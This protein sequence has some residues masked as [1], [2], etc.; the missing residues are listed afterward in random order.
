MNDTALLIVDLQNDYF[1]GGAF[2][3]DRAEEA[4][5]KARDAL[6]RFRSLGRPVVH[7]RHET[8]RPGATFFLPGSPG[9][10]IHPLV[11]PLPGETALLK[12]FPNSFRETDLLGTLRTLGVKRLAVAGMMTNMCVDATV[13]AAVD[14]GFE[15]TVLHD[16]CAAAA[17]T[18]QGQ[19]IPAPQV[20][21]AFMAALGMAYAQVASTDD[22]LEE[23]RGKAP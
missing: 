14:L 4:G 3:L 17:L 5:E 13:R 10:Q 2:E 7:I 19:T 8:L 22:Y 12:H 23:T 9:A 20:H 18:F 11:A 15:A 21:G 16:A 1:P 6:K